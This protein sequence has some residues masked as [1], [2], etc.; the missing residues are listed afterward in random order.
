MYDQISHE[1]LPN[2]ESG[3]QE[4]GRFSNEEAVT[5]K[6]GILLNPSHYNSFG[7]TGGSV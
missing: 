7:S 3:R 5:A 4:A 2:G 1:R 6:L